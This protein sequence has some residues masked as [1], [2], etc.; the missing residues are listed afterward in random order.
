MS[1]N[2]DEDIA[3]LKGYGYRPSLVSS[4]IALTV[5]SI[6][7]LCIIYQCIR[8]R[9][10][11]LWTLVFGASLEIVGWILQTASAKS[12]E[13]KSL[14]LGSYVVLL[15]APSAMLAASYTTFNRVVRLTCPPRSLD[16][17]RLWYPTRR[18]ILS[19]L[20]CN[21]AA[22][23]PLVAQVIGGT[24]MAC[25]FEVKKGTSNWKSRNGSS[26][27]V[28]LALQL[29]CTVVFLVLGVRFYF[30]KVEP[31]KGSKWTAIFW[32]S[33]ISTLMILIRTVYTIL[34]LPFG[35]QWAYWLFDSIPVLVFLVLF[36]V[37]HPGRY[38]P[39]SLQGIIVPEQQVTKSN[40]G[41]QL[42]ELKQGGFADLPELVST[43]PQSRPVVALGN[44]DIERSAANPNLHILEQMARYA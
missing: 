8:R 5:W 11:F 27:F 28:G 25:E 29:C 37:F 6:A 17:N 33:Q 26:I 15:V 34:V 35:P 21:L 9:T 44:I 10:S 16:L 24:I 23:V 2:R 32:T 1:G 43:E 41:S 7:Y 13:S 4:A 3:W 31:D 22:F 42:P 39:I 38:L 19:E 14:Y 40:E 30:V 36:A 12:S 18:R 20:I